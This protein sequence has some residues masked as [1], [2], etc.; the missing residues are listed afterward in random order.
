M[1]FGYF[2]DGTQV[3]EKGREKETE[4]RANIIRNVGLPI[5]GLTAAFM[6]CGVVMIK[7]TAAKITS[8]VVHLYETLEDMLA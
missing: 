8:G 6:L 1:K 7:D 5:L 4:M 2:F 3:L